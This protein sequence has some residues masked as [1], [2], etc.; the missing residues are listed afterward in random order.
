MEGYKINSKDLE[1]GDV[2]NILLSSMGIVTEKNTETSQ[3]LKNSILKLENSLSEEHRNEIFY[4]EKK[5]LLEGFHIQSSIQLSNKWLYTID[6]LSFET[7]CNVI[8]PLCDRIEVLEPLDLREY[9]ITKT[10][11]ILNL[12]KSK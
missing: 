2:F 4:E 10:N 9:I 5:K 11:K 12:Y 8:F 6:M 7:A 3:Q 1:T